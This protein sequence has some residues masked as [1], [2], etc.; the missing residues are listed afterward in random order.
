MFL[1]GQKAILPQVL[2]KQASFIVQVKATINYSKSLKPLDLQSPSTFLTQ[3][4]G[5]V[6]STLETSEL[7]NAVS[8]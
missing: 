1:R 7:R 5:S 4:W 3:P 6:R 2:I 8:L